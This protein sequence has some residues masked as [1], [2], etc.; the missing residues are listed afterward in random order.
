MKRPILA[1]IV[2][3]LI[4]GLILSGC[5]APTEKE[6]IKIG[7]ILGLTGY[8]A[9]ADIYPK[10][11]TEL[12][13]ETMRPEVAG[14]PV[15]FIIEDD[16]TDP[17]ICMDKMRKL[18][19]VD[20]V[21]MTIG[22]TDSGAKTGAMGYADRM[23]VPNIAISCDSAPIPRDFEWVWCQRGIDRALTYALGCFLYD[24]EGARTA[25]GM[26]PDF[27]CGHDTAEGF[28]EGFEGRG[29]K[30]VQVQFF[31]P[32][33]MD[34]A[35]YL[36]KLEE[37]DAWV[38]MLTGGP[39]VVAPIQLE[40][41]GVKMPKYV[42][43][44]ELETPAVQQELDI[45]HGWNAVTA[46]SYAVE[47]P[48]A[49]EFVQAFEARW[50][51]LPYELG[52][53]MWSAIQIAMDALERTGGDT[54]PDALAKALDETDLT[55]VAGPIKFGLDRIG[56]NSFYVIRFEKVAGVWEHKVGGEYEVKVTGRVGETYGLE[57]IRI[58]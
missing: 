42:Y 34:Y 4:I 25:V 54:S 20:G 38:G 17:A 36:V 14:R 16:Q 32:D 53:D 41:F 3:V 1:I 29:G 50:G 31:P 56:I 18:I 43:F 48:G 45:G 28:I 13:A 55:T 12:Y 8:M 47:H 40:E 51:E 33:L 2:I 11:S 26:F 57:A 30:V 58:R 46:W 52:G 24:V 44:S 19:D 5:A 21:A 39:G 9:A 27:V 7:V 35:P 37:A 15:Q 6:S 22:P 49:K 10:M 23:K